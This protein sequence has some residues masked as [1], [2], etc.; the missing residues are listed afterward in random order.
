MEANATIQA[1]VRLIDDPDELVYQQVRDELLKF[2]S[3]V[4]PVLEQ[5]WEQDYYGLL[6]Q[7]RIENLIHDIQFESVKAQLKTWL[8]APDKD[9]L[10]GAIIIAKYQY[11]GL[12]AAL[13]HERIQAIRRDIWLELNDH[14]TAFEQ[15]KIFNRIFFGMHRF[16]GESQ[17]YHTPA[18]SYI[19]TVLESRKGNPLSLCLI[20]SVI[21]QSLDL[22]IYGVNLPNHFVLAYMDSK[23]SAFG[24][25]KEDDD[26]G[27]LFYINAFS[28]G[29]I[30]DAAEIKAFIQGIHLQPDRSFFEPCSN[31]AILKRMLANLIHAFQQVGSA[32]KVAEL[33]ELSNMIP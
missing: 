32:Q 30:F 4:L 33:Q 27:V 17:N 28:K 11:P 5:S 8:Q 12:D 22:P 16:R 19:N 18:N 26:Y 13:L 7:D 3:E 31:S 15:V 9:L 23:H 24:L 1:L 6:F 20:Y 10:S 21:A 29:S 2:G 25:K 14:Q